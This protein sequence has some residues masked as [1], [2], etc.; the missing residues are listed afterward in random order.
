MSGVIDGGCGKTT[1]S[2]IELV[3]KGKIS[4]GT[5]L[6]V[7]IFVCPGFMPMDING[8]QSVFTIASA[9]IHFIWKKRELVEGFIGWPTMSTMTFDE[10]PD[11]LDVLIVGMVPP[12][13]VRDAEVLAFFAKQAPKTKFVIGTCYGTLVLGA[14]GLLVNRRATSN[15][16]AIPLLS[17]FGAIA[18]EGSE[19]VIDGNIYTSGPATGS[20]DASLLVLK[21]LRGSEFA[22]L[23]ELVIEYDPR[24]PFKTGS[25]QL[26]GPEMSLM[27]QKMTEEINQQYYHAIRA[28]FSSVSKC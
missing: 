20:F 16:R 1:K 22:E 19:V 11:D 13:I 28:G 27:S 2:I 9:E 25:P 17:E 6:K 12:E 4:Q 23:A 24:P 8:A 21:Q 14:A 26:A 15:F 7:G 3:A 18:V 10:C 5:P